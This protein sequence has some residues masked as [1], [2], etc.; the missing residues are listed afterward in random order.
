MYHAGTMRIT[1]SAEAMQEIESFRRDLLPQLESEGP[2]AILRAAMTMKEI[3]HRGGPA[4]DELLSGVRKL[5][6][7]LW[8]MNRLESSPAGFSPRWD[9]ILIGYA[10]AFTTIFT[11]GLEQEQNDP[12]SFTEVVR[13]L[14]RWALHSR[15]TAQPWWLKGI[16]LRETAWVRANLTDPIRPQRRDQAGRQLLNSLLAGAEGAEERGAAHCRRALAIHHLVGLDKPG[17]A[18]TLILDLLQ[19]DHEDESEEA[20]EFWEGAMRQLLWLAA[21]SGEWVKSSP[22]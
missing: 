15:S 11:L 18:D 7:R 22:E 19:N 12:G 5:M 6:A 14:P 20:I 17:P 13:K 16:E 8:E 10:S 9:F 1:S 3:L 4:L 21:L 2:H